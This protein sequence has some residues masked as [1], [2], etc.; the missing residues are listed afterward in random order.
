MGE[1]YVVNVIFGASS[2]LITPKLIEAFKR[3]SASSKEFGCHEFKPA[4]S[5]EEIDSLV[6]TK[7][8]DVLICDEEIGSST[9]GSGSIRSWK[10]MHPFLKV[11][12]LMEDNKRGGVKVRKLFEDGEYNG[13]FKNDFRFPNLVPLVLD[14]GDG[15]YGRSASA[16]AEYYGIVDEKETDE[17]LMPVS[18]EV[19][20]VPIEETFD[21][22][23]SVESEEFS[24]KEPTEVTDEQVIL[25]AD[26]NNVNADEVLNTGESRTILFDDSEDYENVSDDTGESENIFENITLNDMSGESEDVNTPNSFEDRLDN[27]LKLNDEIPVPT[28]NV[29]EEDESV[30]ISYEESLG[31]NNGVENAYEP[32]EDIFNENTNNYSP[33]E[34]KHFKEAPLGDT[35]DISF[36][37]EERKTITTYASG[38]HV[39][40]T[41]RIAAVTGPVV[42]LDGFDGNFD[43]GFIGK[44]VI[45]LVE[46]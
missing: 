3:Y 10:K 24:Y 19:T 34:D 11:I 22:N 39:G 15:T 27:I 44:R 17:L 4:T 16:A 6:Q 18:N 36:T 14:N 33:V 29:K 1:K 12:L 42:V 45:L 13:L 38:Q 20:D 5:V 46:G 26:D 7:R 35:Q 32:S 37:P 23:S 9:I 40:F 25:P 21:D 41:A 30:S 28:T 31:D 8:Y 43:P 2:K